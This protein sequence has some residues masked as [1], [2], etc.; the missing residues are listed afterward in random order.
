[1]NGSEVTSFEDSLSGVEIPQELFIDEREPVTEGSITMEKKGP[2]MTFLEENHYGSGFNDGYTYHA[3]EMM[4]NGIKTIKSEFRM[5][6]DQSIQA[7]KTLLLRVEHELIDAEGASDRI[8]RKYKLIIQSIKDRIARLERET[9]LSV[10][11]EGLVM[12]AINPY[13]E[14]FIR[15]LEKYGFEKSLGISTG[16]FD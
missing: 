2:L 11:E 8:E 16:L 14:G 9:E 7:E 15:G 10:E 1:M 6:V 13:R 12:N 4:I 5:A 3:A